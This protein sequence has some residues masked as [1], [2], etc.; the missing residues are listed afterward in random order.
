[1]EQKALFGK[2]CIIKPGFHKEKNKKIISVDKE[3]TKRIMLFDKCLY[4][5]KRSFKYFIRYINETDTFLAPSFIKCP[6]RNRY[7]KY[8]DNNKRNIHLL[9]HDEKLLKNTMRYR[10]KL[11]LYLKKN[12]IVNFYIDKYIKDK[13]K[14]YNNR[15]YT[16]FQYDK[17]PTDNECCACLSVI[18]L[19]S[20]VI[21]EDKK[22]YP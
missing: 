21:N 8:F 7:T 9:A 18:L 15:I 11:K 1:M 16:N 5:E 17:I 22:R 10:V 4:G 13:T 19:D 3:E 20:I 2:D 12:L 14:I 6:Q